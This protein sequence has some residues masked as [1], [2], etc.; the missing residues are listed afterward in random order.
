MLFIGKPIGRSL[1][2]SSHK[3]MK[4]DLRENDSIHM[5]VTNIARYNIDSW[6]EAVKVHMDRAVPG[7]SLGDAYKV[8]IPLFFWALD[9]VQVTKFRR[10]G[11]TGTL[12]SP[13]VKASQKGTQVHFYDM[14]ATQGTDQL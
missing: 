11:Y 6:A 2:I 9:K 7:L 12:P 4:L 3:L 10:R 5:R 14:E 8:Y 13:T 1:M